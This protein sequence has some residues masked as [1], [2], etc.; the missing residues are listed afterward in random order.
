[1]LVPT[2]IQLIGN[3]VALRWS[4]D[5][6]DF[7]PMDKLRAFSPSAEQKGERDLL[8]YQYGGTDQT[9]YPGVTVTNW[10]PVGSYAVHFTFSDGHRTGIYAFEYLKQIAETLK[11]QS[12]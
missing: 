5:S 7:L 6:E 12:D 8:G 3:E 9:E 2:N 10:H 1:M 4:D 11:G